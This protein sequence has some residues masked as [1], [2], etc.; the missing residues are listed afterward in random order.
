M[1]EQF[2][3]QGYVIFESCPIRDTKDTVLNKVRDFAATIQEGRAR[4][5]PLRG[6]VSELAVDPDTFDFVAY[7]HGDRRP[8]PFQTLNF[9]KGTQQPLHS[10]L[11]HFDTSPRTLMS[12]AWVALEDMSCN[13]GPQTK[14]QKEK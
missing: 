6:E 8:F 4:N 2:H 9:P 12:A 14:F 10:V 1:Y 5:A 3:Q 13:N 11:I 7:L